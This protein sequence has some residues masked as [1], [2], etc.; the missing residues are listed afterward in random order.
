V[1]RTI[2]VG[3]PEPL[4]AGLELDSTGMD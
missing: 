4:T 1:A 3:R 2:T